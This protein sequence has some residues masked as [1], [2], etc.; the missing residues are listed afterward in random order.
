MEKVTY[1][2][3]RF[4]FEGMTA[5]QKQEWIEQIEKYPTLLKAT[6]EGFSQEQLDTPYRTGGWTV[7]Q[8]VH[9]VADFSTNV[10]TRFKLALTENNPT[11]KPFLEEKWALLS[12]TRS[13]PIEP[14]LSIIDGTYAR[15]FVLLKSMSSAE[16]ERQFYHPEKGA[17]ISLKAF[18]C[19]TKWHSF[20]HL[21]HIQALKERNNW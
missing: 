11:I 3:G 2:I 5:V 10:L 18:L 17:Q 14:S 7:R 19:F 16:F 1:P 13:M 15:L 4:V 12:D 9:H 6:V 20:H 21:A 8:V